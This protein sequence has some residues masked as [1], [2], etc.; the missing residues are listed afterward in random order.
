MKLQELTTATSFLTYVFA[1]RGYNIQMSLF[2]YFSR[3]TSRVTD[4]TDGRQLSPTNNSNSNDADEFDLESESSK[5]DG[6]TETDELD[7]DEVVQSKRKKIDPE[8]SVTATASAYKRVRAFP[9]LWLKRYKWLQY[10]EVEGF[11]TCKLC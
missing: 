1:P 11:M 9:K 8:K 5:S 10:D 7:E 6:D 3:L 4:V 2:K